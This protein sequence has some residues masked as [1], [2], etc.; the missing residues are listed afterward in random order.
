MLAACQP[1]RV[2]RFEPFPALRYSPGHAARR[3]RLRP[4]YDVLSDGDVDARWP[5]ATSTTSSHVDVP[6]EPTDRIAT[7]GRR[8][9][10][11]QWI[12]DGMLVAR[13]LAVVHA[14]PHALH[15]RRPGADATRS[16]SS[17][18]WRSSTRAP[19][20]CCPTS[21]PRPKAKTDRLD[22]TRAT[23]RQPVAGLGPVAGRRA[24][25]SARRPGRAGRR[26]CT[27]ETASSTSV[28]RVDRPGPARR[29][30]RPRSAPTRC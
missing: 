14:L 1:V 12:A 17:A 5:R 2:P 28:E 4:P 19:A 9:A 23:R 29:D 25:R 10:A 18:R 24:H 22:L 8:P 30:Q 3:R 13:R 15:R 6:L 11:R 16:A 21:A 7:S 20:A 26:R 27:D